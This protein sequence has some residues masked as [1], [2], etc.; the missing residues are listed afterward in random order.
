MAG[1]EAEL[2]AGATKVLGHP[3]SALDRERFRNYMDLLLKWQ[4]VH[5]LVGSADPNWIACHLMLD[6][7]LFLR[8]L[9]AASHRVLDLGS[10]AGFP[11]VPIALV[12]PDLDVTLLEGRQRRASFLAA[13][14]RE[15]PIANASVRGERAEA[16]RAE[17]GGAFDA[18]VMRCVG[19][20][21]DAMPHAVSFLRPG[22]VAIASG[23]PRPDATVGGVE[24]VEVVSPAGA[25]PRWFAVVR[26]PDSSTVPR[27]TH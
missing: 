16:A 7:L 23:P 22:G 12:R 10:G 3:L 15:L 13:L 2:D 19:A 1:W 4:R 26:R 21:T 25:T 5:R 17:L 20:L 18:V 8:V 24:W 11:G 27:A 9:P 6:S 14:V